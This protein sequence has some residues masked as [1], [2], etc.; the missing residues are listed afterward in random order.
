MKLDTRRFTL[1]VLDKGS[2]PKEYY[3]WI[4]DPLITRYLEIYSRHYQEIDAEK[5]IESHDKRSSFFIGIY[6]K[7]GKF[8]GTHS[9]KGSSR[10]RKFSI[11]GLVGVREY[12]GHNV[13]METRAALI[14]FGFK[15]LEHQKVEAGCYVGNSSAIYNFARQGWKK[16]GVLR[17]HRTIEGVGED[18]ILF[19]LLKDEWKENS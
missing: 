10:T 4:Q 15:R 19:G 2:V 16:E 14:T 12:W 3:S 13:I 8:I 7:D 5:Y 17:S 6:T 1:R 11:G 18:L 9:L